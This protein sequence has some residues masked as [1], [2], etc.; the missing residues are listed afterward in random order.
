MVL[1]SFFGPQKIAVERFK[2]E[3]ANLVNAS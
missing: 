1:Q 3:V 2:K